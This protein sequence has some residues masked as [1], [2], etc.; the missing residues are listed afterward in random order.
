MSVRP[1]GANEPW[2][3]PLCRLGYPAA[4][5]TCP[6]DGSKLMPYAE[7]NKRS[8]ETTQERQKRCPKCGTL[9]AADT[10]FCGTDG[11]PLVDA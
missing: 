3:C 9:F 2:I 1:A 4:Q 11:V 7:F 5:G 10:A 6:R 8:R